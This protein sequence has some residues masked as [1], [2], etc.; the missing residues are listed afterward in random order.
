[1]KSPQ[2]LTFNSQLLEECIRISEGL[3]QV[4]GIG[5]LARANY[6]LS[7]I[8]GDL[9]KDKESTK[10]LERAVSLRK[11]FNGLDGDYLLVNGAASD[12][13]DLVPWML[14]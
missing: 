8:L 1:M 6:K 5:H 11:D 4:E 7:Q 3:P 12:F 13:E 9:G 10:C 2:L 14:W